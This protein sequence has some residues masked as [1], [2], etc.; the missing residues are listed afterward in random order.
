MHTPRR[1]VD[2]KEDVTSNQPEPSQYLLR[3]EIRAGNRAKMGF[4]ERVPTRM[5]PSF[6]RR[7]D[8]ALLGM[9]LI[10]FALVSIHPASEHN[11]EE[12][13]AYAWLASP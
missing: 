9:A 5:A 12:L 10:V 11:K 7:F 2:D 1:D 6:R 3:E 4:N 13:K 8:S